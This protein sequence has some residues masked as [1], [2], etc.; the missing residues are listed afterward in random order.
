MNF[1]EAVELA[2][3][4]PGSVLK[5]DEDGVFIVL[6]EDG[7]IINSSLGQQENPTEHLEPYKLGQE[8]GS[9]LVS[10]AELAKF[11]GSRLDVW[12][13][14]EGV[15]VKHAEF[16]NG[17]IVRVSQ[18]LH[19]IPLIEVRFS[20]ESGSRKFNSE[21]IATVNFPEIDL[22]GE[23]LSDF[24]KWREV[25]EYAIAL[26][27]RHEQQ[28]VELREKI[29]ARFPYFYHLTHYRN[30]RGILQEGIRSWTEMNARNLVHEDIADPDAQ[31]WRELTESVYS[32]KIHDYAPLYLNPKNPMLYV[33][34]H[35]NDDLVILKVPRSI[36]EE[37]DYIFADGNAASGDTLYSLDP[38]ILDGSLDALTAE[39]WSNIPDGK[40]RRCA[41]VLIY[42]FVDPRFIDCAICSNENLAQ[43]L[44]QDIQLEIKVDRNMFF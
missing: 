31:R 32:R 7:I 42:P 11:I 2:K 8:N 35:M 25:E 37:V 44:R 6:S 9:T 3:K 39:Y 26:T 12:S 19:Y 15:E 30:L 4:F 36:L 21:S 16:G 10:G 38:L 23:L 40:R 27:K 5:R 24:L 1:H 41:E 43:K 28:K 18:R 34:R 20:P 22:Q 33:R 13:Q 29:N 14:M 17:Q